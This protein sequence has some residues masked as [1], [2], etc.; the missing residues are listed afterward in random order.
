MGSAISEKDEFPGFMAFTIRNFH[1]F[2]GS[3]KQRCRSMT[4]QQIFLL[5]DWGTW[6]PKHGLFW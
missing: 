5:C 3:Q 2:A 6:T 1:N 4:Q